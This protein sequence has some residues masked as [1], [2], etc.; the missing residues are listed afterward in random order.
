LYISAT[1]TVVTGALVIEKEAAQGATVVAKHQHLVYFI[2]E[3]LSGFK[4]YYSEIEK[5]C[6]VVVMCSRKLQHYFE[7]HTIRV[8]MNHPLHDIF[9]NRDSSGRIGKWAIELSKYVI[10]FERRSAIKSQILANFVAEWM[11]PQSQVDIMQESPSL[12]HCD[13]AILLG[14]QKLRAISMQ[15]CMLRTDSKVVSGQIENECIAREPTLERYLAL[16][17]R[18]EGYFRGFTVK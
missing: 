9:G 1:H 5:I 12:V 10:N 11:E 14:L 7:A 2:S 16:V 18:I 15:N 13:E 17:Q 3:I 8:L 4:Q 6:Y